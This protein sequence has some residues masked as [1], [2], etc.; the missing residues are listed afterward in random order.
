[1]DEHAE[2]GFAPPLHASVALGWGLGVLN[3]GDGMVDGLDDRL[4]PFQ[5]RVADCPSGE[6]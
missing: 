6:R 4:A 2:A 1:V 5:L 3:R